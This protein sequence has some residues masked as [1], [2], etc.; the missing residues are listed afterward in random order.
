MRHNAALREVKRYMLGVVA[1]GLAFLRT[2]DIAEAD[3][4]RAVVV[5][6]FDGIAVED[7]DNAASK[8]GS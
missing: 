4:F 7:G 8:V 2:V 1:V 3:T 6:D 5:E